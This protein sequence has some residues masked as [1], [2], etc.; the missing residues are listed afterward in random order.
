MVLIALA[1]LLVLVLFIGY[2]LWS[3]PGQMSDLG[4]WDVLD[5]PR[6]F[7]LEYGDG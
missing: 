2:L 5:G 4:P 6:R 7:E 1:G 3:A